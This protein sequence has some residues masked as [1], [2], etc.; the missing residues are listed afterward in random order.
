MRFRS[1]VCGLFTSMLLVGTIAGQ[2]MT[3]LNFGGG[4]GF[5]I[6]T[7]R[8]GNDLNDGWNLDL[9]GGY[10]LSPHLALDLD[11]SYNR[12]N[13][14]AAAQ[15]L[16]QQP[17]GYTSIWSVSLNP[18]Y[19]FSP[20]NRVDLY[21]FG[22]PGLY[23]RNLSLTQPTTVTTIYCDPFFGY[24]YP[25]TIGVN[26]VVASFT[27]YKGGV[28]LGG[29]LEFRIGDSKFRA[30]SEARYSRMFTTHGSDLVYVPVT[31]GLRW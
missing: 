19:R 2:T 31:F 6:P 30:F 17:G 15:A 29:G 9:R 1:F 13:L 24:C 12:C 16:Y 5:S 23:H 28:N 22:G 10:N 26:Q 4:A 3:H 18:V 20:R 14:N 25:A 27:T 7:A 11:F 21:T 8:A